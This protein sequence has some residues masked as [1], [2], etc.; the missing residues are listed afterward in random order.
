[1]IAALSAVRASVIGFGASAVNTFTALN[2]AGVRA[3]V[4]FGN[5]GF[6]VRQATGSTIAATIATRAYTVSV[7]IAIGVVNALRASLFAL[8]GP[9]G[10]LINGLTFLAIFF[11]DTFIA[12]VRP[13]FN[14][15]LRDLL[16]QVSYHRQHLSTL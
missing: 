16:W 15:F 2:T 13:V 14:F 6:A 11:R 8:G 10:L 5:V 9:I 7:R 3:L 1:M 12:I 4:Q